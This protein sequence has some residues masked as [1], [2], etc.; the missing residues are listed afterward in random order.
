MKWLK[1]TY[2]L[3]ADH[4]TKTLGALGTVLMGALAL[5]PGAI[6]EAAQTYLGANAAAKIGGVLFALVI[7]RGWYT[8]QKAKQSSP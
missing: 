5:D 3:I 6:R 4:L 1:S 8:G 7:A 2:R